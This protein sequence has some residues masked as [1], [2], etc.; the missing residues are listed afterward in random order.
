[1]AVHKASMTKRGPY[2]GR[3]RIF[4]EDGPFQIVCVVANSSGV[5]WRQEFWHISG[6]AA[7]SFLNSRL[8]QTGLP[9]LLAYMTEQ[10]V[11][12]WRIVGFVLMS[13]W[14]IV[15][16]A[17]TVLHRDTVGIDATEHMVMHSIAYAH[18]DVRPQAVVEFPVH[19][20]CWLETDIPLDAVRFPEFSTESPLQAPSL[21]ASVW[22]E[23][24]Q[25]R[26]R[27]HTDSKIAD[28]N[29]VLEHW[30]SKYAMAVAPWT[31]P[32][33]TCWRVWKPVADLMVHGRWKL[34]LSLVLS[35][36]RGACSAC[37]RTGAPPMPLLRQY[38]Q[39]AV[40][41]PITKTHLHLPCQ[42]KREQTLTLPSWTFRT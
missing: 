40:C 29:D 1:M 13:L 27:C 8:E 18:R 22:R 33:F 19:E 10:G 5:R 26:V 7:R 6:T 30:R 28:L 42:S 25:G 20:A 16:A 37:I 11:Q 41:P 38:L 32:P 35:R 14:R 2:T 17:A 12:P 39:H 15:P 24:Q 21:V 4:E 31:C 23:L 9:S 3:F 34:D 36:Q